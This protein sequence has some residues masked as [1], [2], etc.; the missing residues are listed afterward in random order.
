MKIAKIGMFV[1]VAAA[2]VLGLFLG[3]NAQ[4][5]DSNIVPGIETMTLIILAALIC[6]VGGMNIGRIKAQARQ[7]TQKDL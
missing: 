2:F 1:I 4:E 3:I 5:L 6:F 7:N